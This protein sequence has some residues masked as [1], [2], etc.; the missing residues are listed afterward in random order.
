MII[1]S[2][3]HDP[4]YR[5]QDCFSVCPDKGSEKKRGTACCLRRQLLCY[6]FWFSQSGKLQKCLY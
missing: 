6:S 2:V 1:K 3:F 5:N 4:R